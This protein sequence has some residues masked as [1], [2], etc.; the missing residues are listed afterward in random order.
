MRRLN[1]LLTFVFVLNGIIY[2]VTAQVLT[3]KQ[4][5][6]LVTKT[7]KA[8]DVPGIAV[9]IVKDGKVVLSKGYGL[10]S[11]K[12]KQP[13]TETTFFGIASNSKAFTAAGLGM[14]VDEGKLKWDD[15]VISILPDFKM[16]DPFV[17]REFTVRDLLTHRSGL[18]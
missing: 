12:T 11:L 15:K 3:E 4:V 10:R 1:I 9:A 18:G 14:L 7:L 5:D 13:V 8:F 2:N 16:Y 6:S 17:T